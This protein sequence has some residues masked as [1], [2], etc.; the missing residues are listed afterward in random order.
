MIMES[1]LIPFL[2]GLIPAYI[3]STK[4][5]SFGLWWIYG[6]L[7][8]IIALPHALLIKTDIQALERHQIEEGMKKCAYCA[9][10]IRQEAIVCRYCNRS[11][12][13]EP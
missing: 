5:R 7:L 12:P 2:L 13:I 10:L 4:G 1:L 11:T 8:F 6:V 3:A 9:E